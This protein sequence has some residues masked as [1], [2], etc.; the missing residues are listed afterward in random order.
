QP[1]CQEDNGKRGARLEKGILIHEKDVGCLD[2]SRVKLQNCEECDDYI[3]ANYVSTPSNSKRFICTQAPLEKT[4]GDFWL[5]CLQ[6]RAEYIVMLCNFFEKVKFTTPTSAQ[7][8]IT[9]LL[10]KKSGKK[11]KTKHIQWIDW[12]DRGV[13]PP[14]TTIIQYILESLLLDAP[15]E[16]CDQILLKIRA[17][18]AN[19]IQTDQQYLYVHQVLLN[20]F[21]EKHLLDPEWKPHVDR[22]TDEY[23]KFVL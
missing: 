21:T 18:R 3:H 16:E 20:Y 19:T 15:I 5:M 10:I 2:E 22:F 6:E 8:K 7:I 17:Q 11:M 4:C 13:P 23:K 1:L 9:T 14:D 12:P